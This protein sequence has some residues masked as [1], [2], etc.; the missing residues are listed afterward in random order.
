ME[1][2]MMVDLN[3][4]EISELEEV[5]VNFKREWE[6]EQTERASKW[7]FNFLLSFLVCVLI[8]MYLPSLWWVNII[9]ISYF[10]GSLYTMLRLRLKTNQ[11]IIEHQEQLRLVKLLRKFDASPFSKS[12]KNQL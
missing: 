9:V 1:S 2:S 11:Q 7:R 4:S 3:Q 5:L 10:A 8:S 6:Q 12:H